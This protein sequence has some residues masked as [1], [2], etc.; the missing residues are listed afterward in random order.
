[1]INK[2]IQYFI[3][4]AECLSFTKAANEY[5]VSQTAI[6]Q[7]IASL[8][9][10]LGV[11]LFNRNPHSVALTEAGRVYYRRACHILRYYEDTIDQTIA[12]AE[13]YSGYVKV[14]IGVYEYH[15]TDDFFTLLLNRYP[16]IKTDVY[17]YPYEELTRRLKNGELDAIIAIDLCEESFA[18]R[19]IRTKQ[20]FSSKNCLVVEKS[21]ADKY[22]KDDGAAIL[23]QEYLIT[24]CENAGPS[25][26]DMLRNLLV[27]EYGFF[28]DKTTRTNNI[29]PQ[30]LMVRSKQGVAIVPDFIKEIY[31]DNL[32]RIPMY[33]HPPY[34]YEIISLTENDNPAIDIL[35]RL[36]EEM[37]GD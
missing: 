11:K 14:G 32:V 24:N 17:Q 28:P 2:K 12:A 1:M 15:K 3:T 4:L 35:M 21:V 10:R 30:L 34:Q 25:S 37:Q 7:Y 23:K 8:E 27:E 9:Q 5:G 29:N 22:P 33:Q 19:E 31:D 26:M 6:S 13:L 36:S 20:L 18:N 16:D